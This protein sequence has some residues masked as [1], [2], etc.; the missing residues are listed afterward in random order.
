MAFAISLVIAFSLKSPLPTASCSLNLFES[1][2]LSTLEAID[3]DL[4]DD[5]FIAECILL[6]NKKK[7]HF[8]YHEDVKD[9][10]EKGEIK[11][12]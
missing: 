1:I 12:N 6:G 4:E 10:I 8:T 9:L 7:F 2:G 11:P 5:F 3:I